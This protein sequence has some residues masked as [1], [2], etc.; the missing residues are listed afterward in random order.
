MEQ[1]RLRMVSRGTWFERTNVYP[2]ND[3][4]PTPHPSA[5]HGSYHWAFERYD[6]I[7]Q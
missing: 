3:P 5:I 4:A 2:A 6:V 1:V 7:L